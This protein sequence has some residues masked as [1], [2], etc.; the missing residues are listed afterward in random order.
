MKLL[1]RPGTIILQSF[2]G[3]SGYVAREIA[4]RN[5]NMKVT[6]VDLPEVC[7]VAAEIV[8]PAP[9]ENVTFLAGNYMVKDIY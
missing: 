7:K 4:K 3:S 6:V 9:P 8:P 5:G 2:I 1:K